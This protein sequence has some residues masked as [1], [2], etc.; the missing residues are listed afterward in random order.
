MALKDSCKRRARGVERSAVCKR[1][2]P[3]LSHTIDSYKATSGVIPGWCENSAEPAFL[4]LPSFFDFQK[5]SIVNHVP[6]VCGGGREILALWSYPLSSVKQGLTYFGVDENFWYP[7]MTL[8]IESKKSFSVM[9]F[10]LPR[11]ANIPASVHTDLTQGREN[12]MRN[13]AKRPPEMIKRCPCAILQYTPTPMQH[14]TT[15]RHNPG[16]HRL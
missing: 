9:A 4:F 10:R 12:N 1:G 15:Q 2:G 11:M 13:L 7:L 6:V 3:F 5:A 8:S 14:I 16:A